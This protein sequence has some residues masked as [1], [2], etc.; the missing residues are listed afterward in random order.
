[1]TLRIL[2]TL[3]GMTIASSCAGP[4]DPSSPQDSVQAVAS[5]PNSGSGSGWPVHI[6]EGTPRR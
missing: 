2:L 1:M 4:A 5:T 3:I 6:L